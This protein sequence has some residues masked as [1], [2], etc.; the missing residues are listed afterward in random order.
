MCCGDCECRPLGFLLGLPFA[1]LA[2]LLSVLGVFIW[3]IGIILSCLCPC[4]ICVAAIINLAL[5]LIRAPLHVI[6]WFTSK[7]PC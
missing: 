2:T 5:A 7:I 6:E 4:C 3:I 1:L